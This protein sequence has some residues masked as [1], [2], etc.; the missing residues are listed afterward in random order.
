MRRTLRLRREVLAELA[1][2]DLTRVAAAG[3]TFTPPVTEPHTACPT[4]CITCYSCDCTI[5]PPC[6]GG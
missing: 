4:W 5:A 3:E 1:D 2:R 6:T